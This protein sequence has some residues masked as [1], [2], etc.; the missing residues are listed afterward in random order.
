MTIQTFHQLR[1]MLGLLSIL[2]IIATSKATYVPGT[3]GI[4]WTEEQA[5]IIQVILIMLVTDL[6]Y[7]VHFF[8][9]QNLC[10]CLKRIPL[11]SKNLILWKVET[12]QLIMIMYLIQQT[13]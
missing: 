12:R 10:I 8:P 1:I 5:S 9:R 7:N 6:N 13:D 11:L 4:Q 3:P 2:A